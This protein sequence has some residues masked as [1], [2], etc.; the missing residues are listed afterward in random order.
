MIEKSGIKIEKPT[1]PGLFIGCVHERIEKEVNGKTVRGFSYNME[2]YLRD[3]VLKY[4]E[5][6]KKQFGKDVNLQT[7]KQAPTPFLPEDQ[8]EAPSGRP[9]SNA[10]ACICPS[11]MN[12][13]TVWNKEEGPPS[14]VSCVTNG[15][16]PNSEDFPLGSVIYDSPD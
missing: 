7:K 12:S 14:L 3:T 6:V 15:L 9:L 5:M 1:G 8:K 13:F 16:D 2:S 11:C 10:K 4:I